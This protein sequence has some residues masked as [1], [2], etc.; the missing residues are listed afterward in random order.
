[1]DDL[2]HQLFSAP[3]SKIV[4][5]HSHRSGDENDPI[6]P[7]PQASSKAATPDRTRT[8]WIKPEGRDSG[9]PYR[10]VKVTDLL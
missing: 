4:P 2:S 3:A 9:Q 7:P 10:I 6:T 8:S 1:V 5:V